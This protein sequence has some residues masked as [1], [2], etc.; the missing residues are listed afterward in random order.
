M[1]ALTVAYHDDLTSTNKKIFSD[2]MVYSIYKAAEDEG[3]SFDLRKISFTTKKIYDVEKLMDPNFF[4]FDGKILLDG[5]IKYNESTLEFKNRTF[6]I[7]NMPITCEYN[8]YQS[9][10]NVGFVSDYMKKEDT[11]YSITMPEITK[12]GDKFIVNDNNKT[13][14]RDVIKEIMDRPDPDLASFICDFI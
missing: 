13:Y 11:K 5:T 9:Y 2:D 6:T 1:N 8:M 10:T 3:D 12:D 4:R 7:K 14:N